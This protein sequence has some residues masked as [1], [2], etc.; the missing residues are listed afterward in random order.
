MERSVL[1]MEH[2][3]HH[4]N[5][6]LTMDEFIPQ[7]VEFIHYTAANFDQV[8]N[9]FEHRSPYVI[10]TFPLPGTTVDREIDTI[11]I[12]FSEPMYIVA[13]GM[14]P[15]END[16]VLPV[17]CID[18]PIWKDE[19]TYVITLDKNQLEKGKT[20]GFALVRSFFQSAKKYSM[21]EDYSYTFKISE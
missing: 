16:H 4:R 20:Y 1:L 14:K 8:L 2:F 10:S 17:P 18:M 21:K 5:V 6:F 7:L 12:C 3:R 13:H 19:Y 11:E 15:H 9:E